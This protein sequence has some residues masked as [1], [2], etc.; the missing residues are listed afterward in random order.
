MRKT[1]TLLC[2][3]IGIG[4][5]S[6]QTKITGTVVSADDG[7]PVIGATVLA[8]GTRVGTVTNVDGAF[9]ITLPASSKSLVFSY[10]GMA[11]VELTPKE[12]MKVTLQSDAKQMKEVVVTALGI[13]RD[14]KSLSYASQAIGEDEISKGHDLNIA[15]SLSGNISGVD[16]EQS[17]AGA[18]GSTKITLRG[19]KNITSTN[20]PLF[21]IDGVPMANYQ[22][23][24]AQGFYGGRDSG[25]GLSNINPD[26]IESMTVLKG[27]NA[28]ALYGSQG[29]NGV[30][31]I[32]TKKGKKGATKITVSSGVTITNVSE[33]PALQYSYGETSTGS[34]D[35]WGAKGNYTNNV[36]GFFNTGVTSQ[37]SVSMSGGNDQTTAY[38]SYGNANSTGVMPTNS[39]TK[40]N[41][42]FRQSTKFFNDKLTV[43]S[44]IMLTSETLH[45]TVLSGYYW[46]PL[47]GLYNFPRGL[48]FSNYKNNYQVLDPNRN[49]MA[50][51]WPILGNSEGE[52][53]PYWILYNDPDDTQTK[54][55]IANVS[56]AYEIT[57]GL[58]L[59]ARGTYDYTNQIYN[60]DAKAT[61]SPVLVSNNGRYIYSNLN[62]WQTYGD[63]M[64]TYDKTIA[65]DF[66]LH[67]VVGTS[68]QKR[69]IGDGISID[70]NTY[71]LTIVN[72]F[73]LQNIASLL[74]FGNAQQMASRLI[75]ESVFANASLGYKNRIYLDLS[76]RSDW[77]SSLAFTNNS[78]YFYPS[79]GLSFIISQMVDL[80]KFINFA[81]VR[82]SYADV[83]NEIPSFITNP[84]NS[85]S[86]SGVSLNTVVP[87]T[88]LKPEMQDNYE[89]G[90]EMKFLDNR[91]G[92]EASA[93]QI[94]SKNQYLQLGAPSGSGY[95]S[96]YVN[97]GHIRTKGLEIT[98]SA[99][100]IKS[101]DFTWNTNINYS[102]THN[103]ILELSDQLTGY[104]T[105]PGGGEG[106]DMEVVKGGSMGDIYTYAYERDA[107]GNIELDANHIPIKNS[108][109]QKMGNANPDWM[110]GWNNSF[111]YKNFNL[112]FLIDGKFGGKFV[113]M[114]QAYLDANGV[115][116]A[117]ADARNAGGVNVSG[118]MADGS[119][120]S[121][122]V[123]AQS[124]YQGIAGRG[125][126]MEKYVYDATNVRLRQVVLGYTLNLQKCSKVFTDIN[127]SIVGSNL[128]FLYKNCPGDPNTTISTG[129]G[130]QSV[131][132]FGMPP[133]RSFTF[134]VKVNL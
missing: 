119:A 31:L 80:P 82:T 101:K 91:I 67:A 54:R 95:T 125:G 86:V 41:A 110:M 14:K 114:T 132:N 50:Q 22:T 84:T 76:G 94:D 17:A 131:E 48:D 105:L 24:D 37:S 124:Y 128:F 55:M 77:A 26:E 6:A 19:D 113:S 134:N 46:N 33:L 118:V 9:T 117:T 73:T 8:K 57:K 126:I 52:M 89:A 93:Y 66:D 108:T 23:S 59:S 5:A 90:L 4:W 127:F 68:Y 38:F 99:T 88:E 39:Y 7:Q 121:G 36:K 79:A 104:Y 112:S 34:E 72:N 106:Y 70:S 10:V 20:Q 30:I 56:M 96:Y 42:S 40:N 28:A 62:S 3:L 116:Q 85:V 13:K 21:V 25:D 47:L 102:S 11:S 64:L 109:E 129:N 87:F 63:L 51:N 97:A 75:K 32:T 103:K 122:L 16:V 71:G 60:M 35:S 45:N 133:T 69:V 65:T 78:S 2:F 83:S 29:S 92:L 58:V 1:M 74:A 15:S 61:S 98:L 43:S 81:K 111:S 12:G 49:I 123:N 130:T 120:W 27:A 18:G 44:N 53:N 115:T 100:P 107:K